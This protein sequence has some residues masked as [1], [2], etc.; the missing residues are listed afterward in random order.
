MAQF[1]TRVELHHA[2]ESDYATLH[3]AME[4]AGFSRYI[5]GNAGTQHLPTAE[6][7]L[8]GTY[9]IDT[10][11]NTAYRAASSTGRT[12]WLLVSEVLTWKSYLQNV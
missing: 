6:Y 12:F 4:G 7:N 2:S 5:S 3:A 10:V 8:I 9:H 1:I 11:Y